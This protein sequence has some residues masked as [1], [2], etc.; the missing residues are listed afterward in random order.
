MERLPA[1]QQAKRNK[2]KVKNARKAK[3]GDKKIQMFI[4]D[5]KDK[6]DEEMLQIAEQYIINN[7]CQDQVIDA[8]RKSIEEKPEENGTKYLIAAENLKGDEAVDYYKKG[9]E[10]LEKDQIRLQENKEEAKSEEEEEKVN[11]PYKVASALSSIA[12]LYMTPPLCDKAEA[13]ET[14]EGALQKA[15]E[16]ENNNLDA[17][18]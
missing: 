18:Q 2:K 11:I 17:L 10:V 1:N 16:I 15:L 5:I 8:I 4:N 7:E 6:S 3:K 13:E 14:C 9:I 12:E